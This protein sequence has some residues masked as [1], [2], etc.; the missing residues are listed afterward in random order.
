MIH[1][2][3][4]DSVELVVKIPGS[5]CPRCR[6]LEKVVSEVIEHNKIDAQVIK[7]TDIQEMIRFGLLMT[8]GLVINE[9]LKSGGFI[10]KEKQILDWSKEQQ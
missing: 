10:P 4:P 2:P 7:V 9:E 8:P 3:K 6:R 1:N 5:G